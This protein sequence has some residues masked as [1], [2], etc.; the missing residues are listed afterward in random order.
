MDA[1][2]NRYYIVP[3]IMKFNGV[4]ISYKVVLVVGAV[5]GTRDG[6]WDGRFIVG[7]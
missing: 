7:L 1:I 5:L 2:G 3:L 6:E 4:I